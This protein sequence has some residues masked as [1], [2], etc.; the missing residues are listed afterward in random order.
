MRQEHALVSARIELLRHYPELNYHSLSSA[1]DLV[2]LYVRANNFDSALA[3]GRVVGADLRAAFA[4]LT[5]QCMNLTTLGELADG[6]SIPWLETDQTLAWDGSTVRRAWHYLQLS[7]SR[8]DIQ[9]GDWAYRKT[10]MDTMLELDRS[11]RLPH[12]LVAFF[13]EKQPDYLVRLCLKYNR[14][15]EALRYSIRMVKEAT[16]ALSVMP[17][18]HAST[19][20]LPYSLLDQLIAVAE[21]DG[22]AEQKQLAESLKRDLAARLSK[23][24]RW[25]APL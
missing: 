2:S 7:L 16:E 22:P 11:A 4:N 9:E 12:W 6:E 20:C 15:Q 10:V 25:S 24:Q 18:Q 1:Q 21:K 8:H 3:T 13:L 5:T 19:T 23:L 14:I 17:P